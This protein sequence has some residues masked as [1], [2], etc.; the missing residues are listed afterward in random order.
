MVATSGGQLLAP[1]AVRELREDLLPM[2]TVVTPNVPEAKLLL[3]N[4]GQSPPDI[5]CVE[6]LVFMA[7]SI[8]ALGPK[9]VLVKGGHSPFKRDGHIACTESEKEMMV[10]VLYGEGRVTRIV[11]V[12]QASRNTHGTGCSLA[13]K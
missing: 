4:A 5:S 8:Q 9:Y 12:Y 1:D 6:D 13:C 2:A 7:K 3:L 10:D 11:T